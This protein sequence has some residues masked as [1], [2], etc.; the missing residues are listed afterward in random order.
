[1]AY[2]DLLA[3]RCERSELCSSPVETSLV[4]LFGISSFLLRKPLKKSNSKLLYL[5]KHIEKVD[6][7]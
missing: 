2:G 6:I 4:R 5:A 7:L 3:G 1:M